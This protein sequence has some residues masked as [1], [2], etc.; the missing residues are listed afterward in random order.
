LTTHVTKPKNGPCF[1]RDL[2]AFLD[3]TSNERYSEI[4]SNQPEI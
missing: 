3:F 2:H 4:P 1:V